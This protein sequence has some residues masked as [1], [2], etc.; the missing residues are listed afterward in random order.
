[1]VQEQTF[2]L[3]IATQRGAE[4]L[5]VTPIEIS[6][7]ALV[8]RLNE[9]GAN[10]TFI[11]DIQH[12]EPNSGKIINKMLAS[13]DSKP[14][15][16]FVELPGRFQTAYDAYV[17]A[18]APVDEVPFKRE[19]QNV[20]QFIYQNVSAPASLIESAKKAKTQYNLESFDITKRNGIQV[21]MYDDQ[22][23]IELMRNAVA[24]AQE[25]ERFTANANVV[26]TFYIGDKFLDLDALAANKQLSKGIF[27]RIQ[28]LAGQMPF[29]LV[30]DQGAI[31]RHTIIPGPNETYESKLAQ[32]KTLSAQFFSQVGA[33]AETTRTEIQNLIATA[34][35]SLNDQKL[36]AEALRDNFR[37]QKAY[38]QI[39]STMT[40]DKN[41]KAIILAGRNH[42][43]GQKAHASSGP[44]LL[45]RIKADKTLKAAR[46]DIL[47]VTDEQLAR[48]GKT[49]TLDDVKC[50]VCIGGANG[51][52]YTIFV[53]AK[54]MKY[55]TREKA[56][57]PVEQGPHK[58]Q[59]TQL[60]MSQLLESERGITK[61]GQVALSELHDMV[62]HQ[63]P[64]DL[65][66][67][68]IRS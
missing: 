6:P 62:G 59:V 68:I 36:Q 37:E 29:Y 22:S 47:P 32:V 38:E 17:K 44:D 57:V 7:D 2:T 28:Q 35:N 53:N 56:V 15:H 51:A 39:S 23:N 31:E 12:S 19:I 8:R 24:K 49:Q 48:F 9:K 50:A 60:K 30:S 10:L 64:A 13:N 42:I 21:H 66:S 16:Y 5:V 27:D 41:G 14:G 43:D 3:D 67:Q 4:S 26:A 20:S 52:D 45:E 33:T 1:M 40:G 54:F 46:I 63:L 55:A 18:S 58:D 25:Y 34:A 61:P 65:K 11:G